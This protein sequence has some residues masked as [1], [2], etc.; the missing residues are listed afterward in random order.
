MEKDWPWGVAVYTERKASPP[1]RRRCALES[2]QL[3]TEL[4]HTE[5]S[6]DYLCGFNAWQTWISRLR[7]K[8]L[9]READEKAAHTTTL[10]N[11]WI[12]ESL[13]DARK[14]AADFFYEF[15]REF[16]IVIPERL[17]QVKEIPSEE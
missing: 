5:K 6:G 1:D 17:A 9:L 13:V 10:G 8:A 11:A 15:R 3:A 4:A 7:D 2:L 14:C 16:N 12:Y